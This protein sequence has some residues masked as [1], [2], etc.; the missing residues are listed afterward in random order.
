MRAAGQGPSHS[1][2]KVAQPSEHFDA[3][4]ASNL[5]CD[6]CIAGRDATRHSRG[7][8]ATAMPTLVFDTS[9]PCL[10]ARDMPVYR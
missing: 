5:C 9:L 3:A 7:S 10:Y 2:R 6:A 1:I 4:L 8:P